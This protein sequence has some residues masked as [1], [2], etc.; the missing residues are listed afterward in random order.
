MDIPPSNIDEDDISRDTYDDVH[1][2]LD[3]ARLYRYDPT[4]DMLPSV[5]TVLQ[6]RDEDKSNL[7][8]WQDRNDG[9]GDNAF[10]KHL[11]WYKRH[12]GTLAHF[13]ALNRAEPHLEWSDDEQQSEQELH[14]QN[15][16]EVKNDSAR[17]VLY[18]VLKS[19]HAVESW[20]EFYD[21]YSPYKNNGYYARKLKEQKERDVEFFVE[22]FENICGELDITSDDIIA[23]EEFL[24]NIED[25]Y[26]GQVDLVYED[27]A[28]GDVVVADLKTSSGCYDKHKIQGAAY[29]NS[30]EKL[31]GLDVDRLEVWRIH[32]DSGEWAV[33]CHDEV[34]PIHTDD[35]WDKDYDELL[36]TFLDLAAEFEFDASNQDYTPPEERESIVFTG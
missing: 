28:N 9:E 1:E 14:V 34:S 17:E 31:L 18:S 15:E 36:D 32:P 25:G 13:A 24:F 27:P 26:A 22:T 33:H 12:R 10:H 29:A 20:G 3:E 23:V 19:Q 11:F 35:W 30:V 6:T 5:T 2:D 4:G 7:Y 16:S 8:D 21:K